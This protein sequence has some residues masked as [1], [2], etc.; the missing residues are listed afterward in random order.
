[1]SRLHGN[2]REAAP[3]A[4]DHARHAAVPH[5]QVGAE[6]DHDDGMVRRKP[7]KEIGKIGRIGRREQHLRRPADPEP[8][9][10]RQHGIGDHP[11]AQIRHPRGDLGQQIGEAHVSP[12]ARR[13]G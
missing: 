8:G 7:G 6:A 12:P 9:D 2:L 11:P 4:D 13:L 10:A 5:Q 3:Q 1:M